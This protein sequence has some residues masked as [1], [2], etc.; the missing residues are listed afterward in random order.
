MS[1]AE[2]QFFWDG[3]LHW[4]HILD[5]V[6]GKIAET[7][8]HHS[9]SSTRQPQRPVTYEQLFVR[10]KSALCAIQRQKLEK[11]LADTHK[12]ERAKILEIT[13]L[14]FLNDVS[15]NLKCDNLELLIGI[16][17][18]LASGGLIECFVFRERAKTFDE[19]HAFD[20]YFEIIDLGPPTTIGMSE[21]T[22]NLCR[23][24]AKAQGL[25]IGAV[26]DND[27]GFLNDAFCSEQPNGNRTTRFESIWL[28]THHC[29]DATSAPTEPVNIGYERLLGRILDK[30]DIDALLARYRSNE[31][32]AYHRLNSALHHTQAFRNAPLKDTHGTAV[33]ALAYGNDFFASDHTRLEIPLLCVQVPPEAAA[34]TSGTYSESAI[35][36]GVR[37]LCWKAR[38]MSTDATLIINIS[39]GVLA[40]PKDGSKFIAQQIK[41]E[42]E[43]AEKL[44][45]SVH[46]VYALGNGLNNKQI[47]QVRVEA[48]ATCTLPKWIIPRDQNRPSHMEIRAIEPREAKSLIHVPKHLEFTLSAPCGDSLSFA[49]RCAAALAPP[50]DKAKAA[51]PARFYD[52]DDRTFHGARRTSTGMLQI[53][54]APTAAPAHQ[55]HGGIL[56]QHGEWT[57]TVSNPSNHPVDLVLQIQ[58]GDTAPGV[59]GSAHQSHFEGRYR[60]NFDADYPELDVMEPLTNTGTN[61][62]YTNAEHPRIHTVGAQQRRLDTAQPANYSARGAPWAALQAPSDSKVVDNFFSAGRSV[63]GTYSGTRTRLSGT[64]AAAALKSR[65]LAQELLAC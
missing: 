14:E 9:T 1:T 63:T 25:C 62:A 41:Q 56:A 36:Q 21:P 44:G 13:G 33:A 34:D 58:R 42:I 7:A 65:A 53:A 8:A 18:A 37:W 16:E 35:V 40:G 23:D 26:I 50:F 54:I 5:P 27:I 22:L 12:F 29:L 52:V 6:A 28:Q 11:A 49:R 19:H 46:V 20:A 39:Y 57:L 38:Q 31:A 17:N 24:E 2:D 43:C 47:A 15:S 55:P 64:S 51:T 30:A 3:Y 45:L 32:E 4:A 60:T 59:S 61:S 48:N 10:F